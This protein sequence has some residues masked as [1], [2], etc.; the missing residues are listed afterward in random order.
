MPTNR[1]LYRQK[2][3]AQIEEWSAHLSA[4]KANSDKLTAQAKIDMKPSLEALKSSYETAKARLQELSADAGDTLEEGTQAFDK[5]WL[6]LKAMVEGG[7]DAVKKHK[8]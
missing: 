7:L 1:E 8:P 3:A 5:A 6:E 2:Y 4:L